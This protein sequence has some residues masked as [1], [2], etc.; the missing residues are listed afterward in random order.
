MEV[1]IATGRYA[2]GT[3]G[4]VTMYPTIN[5][6]ER[7][8][9]QEEL[10]EDQGIYSKKGREERIEQDALNSWEDAIMQGYE[11]DFPEIMADEEESRWLDETFTEE[12]L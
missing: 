3:P 2:Y 4:V 6:R 5:D 10:E 1:N 11:E 8:F 7:S 12:V 9:F